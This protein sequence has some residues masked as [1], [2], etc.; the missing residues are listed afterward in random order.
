ME[1]TRVIKFRAWDNERGKMV[2][3]FSRQFNGKA[4]VLLM[5]DDG[6]SLFCGN[7]QDNGDW[8]EPILMQFTGLLDKN[9]KEIYEGDIVHV[10]D[11]AGIGDGWED[12]KGEVI[13][14]DGGFVVV[15]ENEP[16]G[17]GEIPMSAI[18]LEDTEITGNI[19]EVLEGTNN[20]EKN[21]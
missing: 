5:T 7:Y 3:Q 4:Y 10:N 20:P 21:I 16:D 17:F 8:N 1:N 12:L 9:G 2:Y 18:I 6:D 13:F 11:F 19:Y 14:S 15:D